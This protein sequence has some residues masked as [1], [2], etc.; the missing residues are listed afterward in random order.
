M[1]GYY[2][3][4]VSSVAS[5]TVLCGNRQDIRGA[6]GAAATIAVGTVTTGAAGTNA[7]VTNSGTSSA[8]V[9]N[10]TIPR[11]ADGNN[12]IPN[13]S[14]AHPGEG[15][16]PT[17][18]QDAGVH[19][20]VIWADPHAPSGYAFMPDY[21]GASDG[22]VLKYDTFWGRPIWGT[23]SG[24]LPAMYASDVFLKAFYDDKSDQYYADWAN[25]SAPGGYMFV[26]EPPNDPGTTY[27]LK[28]EYDDKSGVMYVG[29]VAE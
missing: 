9:F 2:Y 23:P 26:P 27:V 22:D 28:A 16:V 15:Q 5:T 6:A 12:F 14:T 19:G 17:F 8:A 24:G 3:Y 13:P 1:R 11:G 25:I 7:S 21:S 10:F 4:T 29:W 18:S 20:G